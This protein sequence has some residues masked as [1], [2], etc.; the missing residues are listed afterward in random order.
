MSRRIT[1]FQL[2]K[3]GQRPR[4]R[5][6]TQASH[7]AEAYAASIRDLERSA[8]TLAHEINGRA[9]SEFIDRVQRLIARLPRTL[10][11]A[12]ES[13]R[14]EQPRPILSERALC[15]LLIADILKNERSAV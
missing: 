8:R 2:T 12:D 3:G 14:F 4:S 1:H 7:A 5:R 11:A 15:D 9:G 13:Q 10:A 6:R